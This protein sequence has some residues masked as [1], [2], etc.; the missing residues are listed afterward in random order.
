MAGLHD[1][2]APTVTQ[3]VRGS[4]TR[5]RSRNFMHASSLVA[6][7]LDV[8]ASAGNAPALRVKYALGVNLTA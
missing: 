1:N 7:A 3:M 6:L 2:R 4:D 8:A 5:V